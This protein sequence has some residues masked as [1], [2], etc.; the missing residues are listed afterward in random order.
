[1]RLNQFGIGDVG[2]QDVGVDF[3]G[4]GVER[5]DLVERGFDG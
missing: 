2:S 1:V 4:K 3:G 5:G